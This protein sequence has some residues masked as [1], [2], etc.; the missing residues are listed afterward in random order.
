MKRILL[1]QI[2]KQTALEL[3]SI[4]E[5]FPPHNFAAHCYWWRLCFALF[6]ALFRHILA[7]SLTTSVKHHS[8][9]IKGYPFL[10]PGQCFT[11][12]AEVFFTTN[13]LI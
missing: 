13:K 11:I 1:N 12:A 9:G 8:T 2:N 7:D 6:V 5:R 10:K 3:R 4:P